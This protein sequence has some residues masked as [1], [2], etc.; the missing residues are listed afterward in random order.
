MIDGPSLTITFLSP[1]LH[2]MDISNMALLCN[3]LFS[4]L[5][6]GG[7]KIPFLCVGYKTREN[8]ELCGSENH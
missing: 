5:V 2:V 1:T 7:W 3:R 6:Y 8:N 4:I